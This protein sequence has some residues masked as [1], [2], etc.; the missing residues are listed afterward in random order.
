[1]THPLLL[2]F[3]RSPS[4]PLRLRKKIGKLAG[5][6]VPNLPFQVKV[7]GALFEGQTGN[8][9]DDKIYYYGSHEASTLRLLRKILEAQA[10]KGI[11]PVYLDIGTNIGQH[12]IA[13]A[14]KAKRAYGFE[15]WDKV[16]DVA[17]KLI[18]LND[19]NHVE[20]LPFG[21]SDTAAHL[22][23]FPPATGNLGIGSF[24][25]EAQDTGKPI[26]LEVRKGDD[27]INQM[28]IK[29]SV[30]K[31]DTEG[32]EAFVLKGLRQTLEACRPAVI[33]ELGDLS[34]KDFKSLEDLH[35][36]FPEGYS[37]YGIR[38]S[39][40]LPSLVPFTGTGKFENLVAWPEKKLSL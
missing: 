1:M 26:T 19:F 4:I 39:R 20:V 13:V 22:P 2:K 36:F 37:F 35:S 27:V 21:L 38:R 8:H 7:F 17:L 14:S 34:R 18:A 31:I 32:F 33:F 6:P 24:M 25:S 11:E 9:Q 28:G 15:P 30:L 12:L 40:E 3:L 5:P 10:T 29:P 16:R 23:Y